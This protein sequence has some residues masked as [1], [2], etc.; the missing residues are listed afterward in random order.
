MKTVFVVNPEAG[1]GKNIDCLIQSINSTISKLKADAQVYITKSIGDAEKYVKNFCEKIGPARFI[2]CGGDGTLNEVLN[3]AIQ[4]KGSEI[5][6]VPI[7]TG[8]DFCRN[9]EKGS[10]FQDIEAQINGETVECDAIKFSTSTENKEKEGYCVNMFNIGFDCNVADLT[11]DM[12]KKPFISG[13]LAYFVSILVTLIK[14]KGSNLKIEIDGKLVHNGKLLLTSVANGC[15]CGGGVK[16]NPLASIKDGLISIN[17]IKNVTRRKLITI[18]PH[19][20]K[21]THHSVSGI[22]KY[23]F[24]DKCEK[25]TVTPNDGGMRL[26]VDGEIVDAEKTQFEIVHNAFKFVVPRAEKMLAECSAEKIPELI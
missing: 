16:S 18:L 4:S 6:V 2:A 21:G 10:C 23:I 24:T 19:Y 13:S 17:I 7:G 8:N 20:M 26:C 15:Y 25:V 1:Q 22:E 12:K 11:Q 14:K 5:G 9:F 3:G